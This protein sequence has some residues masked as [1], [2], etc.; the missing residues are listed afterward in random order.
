MLGVGDGCLNTDWILGWCSELLDRNLVGERDRPVSSINR[1]ERLDMRP[2]LVR[3]SS[4][5][6]SD[7]EA[8]MSGVLCTS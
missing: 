7:G 5:T 8:V 1:D 6:S 4:V 3:T 2:D